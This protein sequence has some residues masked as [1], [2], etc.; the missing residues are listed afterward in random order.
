MFALGDDIDGDGSQKFDWVLLSTNMEKKAAYKLKGETA[1]GT[2]DYSNKLDIDYSVNGNSITTYRNGSTPT[3]AITS[4]FPLTKSIASMEQS[5]VE[6]AGEG[7]DLLTI[8]IPKLPFGQA[9]DMNLGFKLF[10]T[11][12]SSLP[13]ISIDTD[14]EFDTAVTFKLRSDNFTEDSA[15]IYH[16]TTQDYRIPFTK[17]GNVYTAKVTHFSNFSYGDTPTTYAEATLAIETALTELGSYT[18]DDGIYGL[19]SNLIG[20]IA[21]NINILEK[22]EPTLEHTYMDNCSLL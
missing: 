17:D 12:G 3:G 1:S 15:F 16:G 22:L 5:I 18:G 19:D 2:F 21:A 20:D 14:I 8:T 11:E 10:Y 7:N 13:H 9:Q 4:E 6:I